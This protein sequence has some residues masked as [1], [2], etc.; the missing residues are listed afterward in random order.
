MAPPATCCWVVVLG[1]FGRSPRMQYHTRSLAEAGYDVHVL[2]SPG[3][4]PIA[5]L[6]AA[7]NVKLHYLSDPPAWVAS[8]PALPTLALKAALQALAMLWAVLVALP[9]PAAILMQNPPAIPAMLV[10]WLAALRH[11][12]ALVIDWHNLAYSI[13]ALKHGRRAWLIV[14]ARGYERLLGRRGAAHF[15]V[16]RAM[17]TFLSREFGVDAVVLYDRPPAVFRAQTLQEKHALL[18]RL[19]PQLRAAALGADVLGGDRSDT[20]AAAA[21][22]SSPLTRSARART[23]PQQPAA[24]ASPS[25]QSA[26]AAAASTPFTQLG[27]DGAVVAAPRRPALVVSS[28]SWTPDEDFGLLLAAAQIYDAAAAAAAASPDSSSSYP[29]VLFV[30]TGRG[31]QR[32]EYLEKIAA[33]PLRRCAFVS[34]WLEPEDYPAL[35]GCADLGV[36]LHTSSSGLDLPMKVKGGA[37]ASAGFWWW[38]PTRPSL[39]TLHCGRGRGLLLAA[40]AAPCITP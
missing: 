38:C 32:D 37:L 21:A 5:P 39:C 17:R 27:P 19:A 13:L 29:D 12:A 36:C 6:L 33:L 30:I 34:A 10:L 23:Q 31:P 20:G 16:T 26:A 11:R 9:R 7:P 2:A 28:T 14:L 35:L 25:S 3:S 8:L 15:C 24:A 4:P 22:A 18:S 1:D 40:A